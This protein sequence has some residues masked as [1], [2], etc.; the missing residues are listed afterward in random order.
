MVE[1]TTTFRQNAEKNKKID[2]LDTNISA[3]VLAGSN[4]KDRIEKRCF[5]NTHCGVLFANNEYDWVDQYCHC[6]WKSTGIMS[7]KDKYQTYETLNNCYPLLQQPCLANPWN[8]QTCHNLVYYGVLDLVP[9]THE[10]LIELGFGERL[11]NEI[12]LG[13][14]DIHPPSVGTARS[15][16]QPSNLD[17]LKKM[18]EPGLAPLQLTPEEI[19]ENKRLVRAMNFE[20]NEESGG[21]NTSDDNETNNEFVNK[22]R[23]PKPNN[24]NTLK[25]NI[26]KLI[27]ISDAVVGVKFANDEDQAKADLKNMQCI[28]YSLINELIESEDYD[29]QYRNAKSIYGVQVDNLISVLEESYAAIGR[30]IVTIERNERGEQMKR[31]DT[32]RVN[33][34][35]DGRSK[36]F[37]STQTLYIFLLILYFLL[38]SYL[39]NLFKTLRDLWYEILVYIICTHQQYALCKNQVILILSGLKIDPSQHMKP[40][41]SG[42][43][44]AICGPVEIM[45]YCSIL[46]IK[47]PLQFEYFNI[48]PLIFDPRMDE[49][50]LKKPVSRFCIMEHTAFSEKFISYVKK[51]GIK[52]FALYNLNI[53]SK[54]E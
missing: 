7:A 27:F 37:S 47:V 8:I 6:V 42:T 52:N 32:R 36:Y 12:Y 5:V 29:E 46:K 53:I 22:P 48:Q 38:R 24:Y 39:M 19:D 13:T 33:M 30:T 35:F 41:I 14:M 9:T 50:K 16:R 43:H 49:F 10:G 45:K 15:K 18:K 4:S 17:M 3:L 40:V 11:K 54:F 21:T 25:A 26:D 34:I 20:G 44:G 2:S 31:G 28:I 23:I 51:N 1:R